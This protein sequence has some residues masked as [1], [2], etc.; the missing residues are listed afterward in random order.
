ME[1]NPHNL[2]GGQQSQLDLSFLPPI[3]ISATHLELADL[4]DLE[5]Q[6]LE[7][8]GNLTYDIK[9]ARIVLSKAERKRR[10]ELDF[11]CSGLWVEQVRPDSTAEA[12][13]INTVAES[14][15]R[16]TKRRKLDR[17]EEVG[18]SEDKAVV[19]DE[20]DS[21]ASEAEE[22]ARARPEPVRSLSST[23]PL[24]ARGEK[25]RIED[26]VLTLLD[27]ETVKVIKVEWFERMLKTGRM[28]PVDE[29]ITYEG[30]VVSKPPEVGGSTASKA[31]VPTPTGKLAS[32]K[33]IL[34][35]AKAD[36][37][38]KDHSSHGYRAHNYR[39]MRDQAPTGGDTSFSHGGPD[40]TD[41][42]KYAHLL[43][44]TT[45]E[46][47]GNISSEIPE[48]PDWVKKNVKY[49][50]ERLTSADPPNKAFIDQLEKIKLARLLTHDE[51][52]VRAYCT[53]IASLAAYPYRI[54]NPRELLHIQAAM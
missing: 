24:D 1:S 47:E 29:F 40:S 35:R 45:S 44:E 43:Q 17:S 42:T 48:M 41:K 51:I 27:S 37:P 11:R 54:S 13:P 16:P 38:Q 15:L 10:I 20:D 6:I 53:S 4:H 9:E 52:G 14:A 28:L 8:G 22:H 31:S 46:H 23:T 30:R 26:R 36:A 18:K 50:C 19:I 3:F 49:A 34:E 5:D 39:R 12:E 25:T 21:T 2:E 33:T 7:V 32:P